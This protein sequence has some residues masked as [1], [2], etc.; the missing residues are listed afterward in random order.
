MSRSS[1]DQTMSLVA[2]LIGTPH[3]TMDC[4][5]IVVEVLHRLGQTHLP[6][7][8][9]AMLAMKPR[10]FAAVQER[11]PLQVGDVLEIDGGVDERG[12]AGGRAGGK[13]HLAVMVSLTQALHSQEGSPTGASIIR[14]DALLRAA[15]GRAVR[16]WRCVEKA[17]GST[18]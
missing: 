18:P 16:R 17:T 10:P 12:K 8:P 5:A 2:N 4:F 13:P 1:L 15:N 3:A 9:E 7:T 11:E 6:R 14:A